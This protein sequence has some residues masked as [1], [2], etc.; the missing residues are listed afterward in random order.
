MELIWIMKWFFRTGILAVSTLLLAGAAGG[1]Q[2]P[3]LDEPVQ[4]HPEG[5]AAID[6]LKSPF[7]PG[8]M[9]EVCPSPQ[10][11]LLRDSLQAM[12]WSG[13]TADS[14]VEWM[15]ANHGDQYRAVPRVAGTG[16]WAWI[17][18][19]LALLGGFIVVAMALQHFR[20]RRETGEETRGQISSEDE[21]VLEEALKELRD[22]EEVPF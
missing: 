12:A 22:S 18:P 9:L 14:L 2:A 6:R 4:P 19:P 5:D 21:S 20:A 7:C 11:K 8:M 1:Q 15:L 10:A 3:R 17:M 13:A 16:L